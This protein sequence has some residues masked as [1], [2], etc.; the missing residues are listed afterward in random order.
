MK[1]PYGYL[2]MTQGVD[3]DHLDCYVGPNEAATHAFIVHQC[4]PK[5]GKY[6]EDKCFLG[7]D[8][9]EAVKRA[10]LQHY[11]DPKFLGPITR[12]PMAEFERKARA[13]REEP[14]KLKSLVFHKAYNPDEPRNLRGEWVRSASQIANVPL[15][16][17]R[18][19]VRF[20]AYERANSRFEGR[21]S[22]VVDWQH[23]GIQSRVNADR[24]TKLFLENA[25]DGYK[26]SAGFDP[27][28]HPPDSFR[29]GVE[30]DGAFADWLG[31]KY[32]PRWTENQ[33][34]ELLKAYNPREPRN[35]HGEWSLGLEETES[36]T[37]RVYN[38]VV[39][40]ARAGAATTEAV[41]QRSALSPR[42][43]TEA[44]QALLASGKLARDGKKWRIGGK[45]ASGSELHLKEAA[46][47]GFDFGKAAGG[48]Q[49]RGEPRDRAGRW[50]RL[51]LALPK[52]SNPKPVEVFRGMSSAEYHAWTRAGQVPKGKHT[53]AGRLAGWA[54]EM[55][56]MGQNDLVVSFTA[57]AGTLRRG[58]A[59]G[60]W[61]TREAIPLTAG[62]LRI[63]RGE[64]K[65]EGP[66]A[67]DEVAP[68]RRK[69]M[70]ALVPGGVLTP[71]H[72]SGSFRGVEL[73]E[74]QR[75][76]GWKVREI[77]RNV[78]PDN[79]DYRGRKKMLDEA[80][81]R[82]HQLADAYNAAQKGWAKETLGYDP[83]PAPTSA[84]I[85]AAAHQVGELQDWLQQQQQQEAE[86]RMAEQVWPPTMFAYQFQFDALLE[87]PDGTEVVLPL[88][89]LFAAIMRRERQRGLRKSA[90]GPQWE[91]EPRDTRGEW[92]AGAGA[93][94][95][96][97]RKSG[98]KAGEAHPEGHAPSTAED[99]AAV[100]ARIKRKVPPASWGLWVNPDPE[101]KLVATYYDGFGKKQYRYSDEY[102][103]EADYEKFGD[104]PRVGQVIP[105]VRKAALAALKGEG[106]TRQ[107]VTAAVVYL[108]DQTGMRIGSE[109]SAQ[110]MESYGAS[111]LRKQ[112]VRVQGN[113]V[114]LDFS[115]KGGVDWHREIENREFAQVVRELLAQPGEHLFQFAHGEG[116]KAMRDG[117]VR[118]YLHQFGIR[119][120]QYR[121]H[122]ATTYCME[123]LV[124]LGFPASTQ[125]AEKKIAQAVKATALELGNTPATCKASY[126]APAVLDAYRHAAR[127][128][129]GGLSL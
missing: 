41:V 63:E 118:G 45:I 26:H 18:A 35:A 25:W 112:H 106:L 30:I 124:Q 128:A 105:Q 13:T 65:P 111:S 9:E 1:Y 108:I 33:A 103:R 122:R 7:F 92:T 85:V 66:A 120:H 39:A 82:L 53:A 11:D 69:V 79:A 55:G 121:H 71:L 31:V 107:R 84:E 126:I 100:N 77:W 73:V 75:G 34:H 86:R 24:K 49:W 40:L 56:S 50:T 72:G 61:I 101:A 129:Q 76:G 125:D 81:T 52:R 46:Q 28:S 83:G 60:H 117:Y 19:P 22:V 58:D 27:S 123:R 98:L 14:K 29:D 68:L 51:A 5:T 57:P 67:E 89:D 32:G 102:T 110:T 91:G 38:A 17:R 21:R 104:L 54:D 15:G 6:D 36:P 43:A 37:E 74:K 87:K 90:G 44:L 99:R 70:E 96:G 115:G 113:R 59:E 47:G 64:L 88:R 119:P 62:D 3:G 16:S 127:P 48:P 2:R 12:M 80:K 8:S 94:K 10:F 23:R 20:T 114:I 97:K 109:G 93:A 95:K 78:E 42:A 116:M 4:D